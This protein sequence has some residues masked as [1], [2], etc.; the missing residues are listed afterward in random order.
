MTRVAVPALIVMVAV[1][2][3]VAAGTWNQSG[4]PKLIITLTERELPMRSVSPATPGD[5]PGLQL[6]IAYEVRPDP[7]DARNW[8]PESRL[9]E[10]GFGLNV[11]AGAPEAADVYDKLPP[12]LAWAALEYDG[13]AWRDIERRL[14]L[15]LAQDERHGLQVRS[16][17]VPVDAAPDFDTLRARY[18]SGHLLVHALIGVI[19]VPPSNGGPLLYGVLRDIAPQTIA[20]PQRLRGVF[21]NVR[22]REGTEFGPR[23]EAEIAVGRLGL[24][25][26]RSARPIG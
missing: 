21:D 20:V 3:L 24:L 1:A 7:I 10:I 26:L 6:A 12:R 15:R 16:R 8:L 5:D 11:P 23:Y 17:L 13:P 9:R 14:A 22:A 18:P 19:Y 25:Y 2:T 4:E